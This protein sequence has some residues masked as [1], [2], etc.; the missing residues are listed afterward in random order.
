MKSAK[1]LIEVQAISVLLLLASGFQNFLQGDRFVAALLGLAAGILVAAFYLSRR[2]ACRYGTNLTLGTLTLLVTTLIWSRQ[3]IHDPA[4]L[5]YPGILIF[6]AILGSARSFFLL[7]ALMVGMSGMLVA[8]STTGGHVFPALPVRLGDFID[9]SGI[10]L[11]SGYG[12]WALASDLKTSRGVAAE[13]SARVVQSQAELDFLAHHDSLTGLANQVR[14]RQR[15]VQ[16]AQQAK[17]TQQLVGLVVLDLDH[18]KTFNESLGHQAGDQILQA[19]ASRLVGCLNHDDLVCRQG[20]DEFVLILGGLPNEEEAAAIAVRIMKVLAVPQTFFGLEVTLTGSL[21]VALHPRDGMDFETLLQKADMALYQAKD[22][23]RNTFRF[24]D[25]AINSAVLEHLHLASGMQAGLER[26]EFLLH[27]QPQFDLASGRIIG[28]EALIRWNHPT[29]GLIPPG[30]FIPVAERAGHIGDLGNW[31]IREAFRQTQ[32]WRLMGIHLVMAVNLSP[33]QFKRGD[34]EQSLLN[35]LEAEGLPPSCI[36]LE[37]TENMLMEDSPTVSNRLQNLRAMGF[38]FS[39]DDFGTGYSNLSYLKR[40]EVERLKIDQSFIR[41][42][43]R[44]SQD[45]AIVRAIIQMAKGL[46]LGTVAEGIEDEETLAR[47]KELGC[48]LGQGFLWSRAL[49]ADEFL[50]YL[51]ARP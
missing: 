43:G 51:Q 24:F 39:I 41:R 21:G 2:G 1:R 12:V 7:L 27:Y 20:G 34:L 22:A 31:A 15:F 38:R 11:G 33:I 19:V 26:G 17:F 8:A 48:D 16:E 44:S 13:Q 14:G 6:A 49:P 42:L 28:A 18:F 50:A 4:L 46:H 36:E 3:G 5:A 37:L 23:G 32:A 40:F 47:L 45:D 10:V 35:A 30:T 9:V 29:L 25:A